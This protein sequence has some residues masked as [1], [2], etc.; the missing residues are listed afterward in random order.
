MIK[1][2]IFFEKFGENLSLNVNLS[3]Y[4]W[5]N[6]G[7]N[8][9]FFFKAKDKNQLKEFL[10]EANKNK[11][12]TIILGAGSNTLFRD[13]GIRGAVIKLGKEFSFIKKIKEDILEVGAATL[14][15]KV[16]NFAKENNLKNLEFL[17]CIPGSIGGAITMNSGCYN[18]DISKVIIS[19][20][21]LDKEKIIESIVSVPLFVTLKLGLT[22]L[23]QNMIGE[24]S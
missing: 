13:K 14:D 23:L 18:D 20:K 5:F 10:E 4:S 1:E 11:I 24:G 8:A 12:K 15:R 2:N 22:V 3:N 16:A 21:V 7:G 17:S 9:D 6:L 19:I